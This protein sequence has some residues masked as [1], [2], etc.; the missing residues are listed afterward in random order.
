MKNKLLIFAFMLSFFCSF[1]Q[2]IPSYIPTNG[3]VSYWGFDGD[4]NDYNS[5]NNGTVVGATLTSDR[6]GALNKAYSFNGSSSRIVVPNSANLSNFNSISISG[7]FNAQAFLSDQGIVTKWFQQ[8]NCSN[9]TDNYSCL[10]SNNSFTNDTPAFVGATN[11][12]TGYTLKSAGSFQTDTWYHFVFVHDNL[13]G[14]TLYINGNQTAQVNTPG[15]LCASTNPLIIGA[16]NNLNTITRFFSG[17]LDDIGI[18]NRT[19]T[20]LEIL[21]IYQQGSLSVNEKTLI[22]FKIYPNPTIDKLTIE[23]IDFGLD[24]DYVIVDEIGRVIMKG[25]LDVKTSIINVNSL[26]KGVYFLAI[27]GEVNRVYKFLK[28]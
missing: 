6:F 28:N 16:D 19:L 2:T 22:N 3:L 13:N 9:N 18:W 21:D 14:G 1:A 27:K 5:S 10:L 17:K 15:I 20:P 4:A 12:Y 11:N 8:L 23:N 25:R 24:A 7:W 26:S